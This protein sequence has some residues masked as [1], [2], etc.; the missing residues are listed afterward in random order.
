M[1]DN[2]TSF[3][4]QLLFP[5]LC[6]LCGAETGGRRDLC[7]PCEDELP[8][9]PAACR[10]CARPL[11]GQAVAAVC[12]A[13][14]RQPPAFAATLAAL[15]YRRPVDELIR[16]LKF[17]QRLQYARVLGALLA[18]R[19][20]DRVDA[21]PDALVPVPLH[22]ARQ[23]QRGFNQATELA[24]P[25]A[26][27]LGIELAAGSCQRV[28]ATETQSLLDRRARRAN[29][30]GAFRMTGPAPGRHV[31]IVDDVVTTGSTVQALARE[32]RAGGVQRVDVWCVA[33]ADQD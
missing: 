26:R 22:P 32:L 13:C 19:L 9:L 11:G 23:R 18:E 25:L 20:Q 2:C 33:R 6:V 29:L 21:L 28:R 4:Q 24:R 17:E 14:Q 16:R 27:T 30:R 5:G 15:Q 31:A 3:L 12:G 10:R 1:V 8:W 7:R